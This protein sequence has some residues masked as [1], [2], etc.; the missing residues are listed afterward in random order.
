MSGRIARTLLSSYFHR[1]VFV[2][3]CVR[4][5]SSVVHYYFPWSFDHFLSISLLWCLFQFL[6]SIL[7]FCCLRLCLC[8]CPLFRV[9][10][11]QGF[12]LLS[13][14]SYDTFSLIVTY[15]VLAV[16]RSW[17]L[18]RLYRF[19]FWLCFRLYSWMLFSSH[20]LQDYLSYLQS[21]LLNASF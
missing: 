10:R 2:L 13:F 21:L 4:A 9:A 20:K 15:F 16:R 1:R 7:L 5:L 8:F 18:F 12:V 14:I 19:L 3:R 17:R 11:Q 6:A